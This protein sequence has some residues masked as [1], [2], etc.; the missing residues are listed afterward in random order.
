[1]KQ[2][3]KDLAEWQKILNKVIAP[4]RDLI[5]KVET[6]LTPSQEIVTQIFTK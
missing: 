4:Y 2:G 5:E 1:V 3:E 6:E